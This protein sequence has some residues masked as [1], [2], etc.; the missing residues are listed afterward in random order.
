MARRKAGARLSESRGGFEAILAGHFWLKVVVDTSPDN[1]YFYR[2]LI[3][4]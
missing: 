2:V 1:G 4:K 3:L